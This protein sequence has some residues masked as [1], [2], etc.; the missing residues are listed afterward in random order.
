MP[1]D[2]LFPIQILRCHGPFLSTVDGFKARRQVIAST[3]AIGVMATIDWP[4]ADIRR[5][6]KQQKSQPIDAGKKWSW[7]GEKRGPMIA[8]S[9]KQNHRKDQ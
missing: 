4:E 7:A 1:H 2:R 3:A 6:A 9:T 8:S 5:G